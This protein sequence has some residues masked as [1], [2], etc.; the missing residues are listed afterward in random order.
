M[1]DT[2]ALWEVVEL[3]DITV[4]AASQLRQK[5]SGHEISDRPSLE[6][7]A[8]FL[9]RAQKGGLFLS[10]SATVGSFDDTLRPLNWATDTYVAKFATAEGKSPDYAEV[11]RYL[12]RIKDSI[13]QVLSGKHVIETQMEE[14]IQF[15]ES[16]ASILAAKADLR[17]QKESRPAEYESWIV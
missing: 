12:D 6:T 14:S 5:R 8:E 10:G 4:R 13:L 3:A 7:M 9:E 17:L 1:N 2:Q 16:L 15:V 11:A